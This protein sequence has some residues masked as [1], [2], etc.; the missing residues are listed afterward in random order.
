M[1]LDKKTATLG[2]VSMAR[3]V[4]LPLI[5]VPNE[6]KVFANQAVMGIAKG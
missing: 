3:W 1:A 4:P 2:V 5:S 6:F